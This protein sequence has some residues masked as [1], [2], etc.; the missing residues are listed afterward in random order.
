[1]TA[2]QLEDTTQTFCRV[3]KAPNNLGLAW[4]ITSFHCVL[5]AFAILQ[6]HKSLTQLHALEHTVLSGEISICPADVCPSISQYV[7]VA[8]FQ[9]L[10]ATKAVTWG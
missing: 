4:H 5:S 2:H 3:F 8:F 6:T 7:Y 9:A 10:T 1:M